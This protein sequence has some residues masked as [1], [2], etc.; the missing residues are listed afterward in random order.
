[1]FFFCVCS[2]HAQVCERHFKSEHLRTTST[3]TDC[4]GRTIE[5]PMKLTRLTPD[6][7]PAIFPDCPSY[8]SDSRTSR[9]EPELKRKRTENE[10]L[11]KA[12]H[13]SQ[14][15]FENEEKQYKVCNLGELISRV[16][17]R[18]NKKFWCTTACETCLIVAHIEPALQAPEM[19]VSVVVT[20][21]LSVSVYFKCAPLVSDDVCIPDEVRDV[22]VLDN[23]LDSV[24]RYCEKKARQQEDKVGGVLRLVLSLLDDI[25]DDEL[26]DDERADA[27][28]FLKEQCKLLTKKS[29][30]VRYSAELLVF[31]SILHT[32][33]PH[34]YKF[35]RHSNK[36]VLPHDTTIKRVCAAHDVSP[37]KEQCEE[38]FLRYIKRR[39]TILKP[40]E[41]NVTVMLDEIHLQQFFEYKGGCLTGF[42]A[43]CAEPAKTAHVFTVQSLLSSYKDVAHILPVTRITATELHDVLKTLIMRLES[44]GLHVVAVV[45][46]NNAINRK[47]MSLFSERNEPG[48]VFPHPANPQQPL[49]HVVDTVHLLKCIR[50]NWLNQ[51]DDDKS[52]LY[53]PFESCGSGEDQKASFTFLRKLYQSEQSKLAKVAYG[54][55]YKA[56][57]PSHL[58]RQNVKLVL[59]VFNSFVSSALSLEAQK[60][61]LAALQETA[62]FIDLIV[63]WW[64]I[65]NVKT[66]EKGHRLRDV[67]QQPVKDMSCLQVQY[68]DQFITWL[69]RWSRRGT[70]AGG[71][72]KETH[73]ALRLSTYSLIELSRYCLDELGFRYVL[74]GKFQTDCLEARFGKYRQMC[75]SHYNVSITEVF[76]AETKIRL[77]DT[78]KLEDM[79]LSLAPKE[80]ELDAEMLIAKYA[81]KLTQSDLKAS[82]TD[83]PALAYI[84]GYCAHAAI[85]RQPCEDCQSQLMITDRELQQS[86]HVLIDSMSRG[87]LKFPQPFVVN[88]VLGTKIVLEH[89]VSKEQE[90]RFH[91]EANQRM[92]LLSIMQFLL[93]DGEELDMCA[94]GHHPDTVLKN[95]LKPA[96]NTLLKNYVA[97]RND[98]VMKEKACTKQRKL[99]TLQ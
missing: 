26:H 98:S 90:Q 49:F 67:Y 66:P 85:K 7:F 12:I 72:T 6:A 93:S 13:E 3:Y 61:H 41:K 60:L 83:V 78:L 56:L 84:A 34:A 2:G 82:Q 99:L 73:F 91:A 52:F 74:L 19:L 9:E 31:S 59:K 68:L 51:K 53:P 96:V 62:T 36:L 21:D 89:L 79:P 70:T 94:S 45:T 38:G 33:S 75:G 43:H 88:V 50:N 92:V 14:A 57:Y 1:M 55:S 80:Q 64:S 11:Q 69:D 58:E 16:N 47:M 23:L 63:R 20:E 95:I 35:F 40:H 4:D 65:V 27:L 18:P 30:G 10:L 29:N 76:E 25:C 42:A 48:I 97:C 24:E 77:Q 22:R 39:A 71:L 8:I 54:L 15:A 32:I 87:G 17:E 86:E 81:I 37:S 28:I 5:A 46:D 44:A